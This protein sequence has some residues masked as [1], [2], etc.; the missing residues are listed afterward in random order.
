MNQTPKEKVRVLREHLAS[1]GLD[2]Y[3]A[4]VALRA[5]I[6]DLEGQIAGRAPRH[7]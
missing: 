4:R 3:K 5:E 7:A 1:L 2:D 6:K